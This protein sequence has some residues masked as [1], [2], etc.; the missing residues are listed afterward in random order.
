MSTKS[1]RHCLA[2]AGLVSG[3]KASDRALG[4]APLVVSMR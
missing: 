4:G 1:V 2:Q 3:V